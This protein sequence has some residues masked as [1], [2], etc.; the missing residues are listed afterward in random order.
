MNPKEIFFR[1][2]FVLLFIAVIISVVGV[3]LISSATHNKDNF[4]GLWQKQ[5]LV[6]GMGTCLMIVTA[7]IGYRFF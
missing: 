7:F 4:A 3:V 2:D 1:F 5:L 6:A